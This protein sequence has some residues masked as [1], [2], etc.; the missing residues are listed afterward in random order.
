MEFPPLAVEAEAGH[1]VGV[2]E[3][4][5]PGDLGAIPGE[6][7]SRTVSVIIVAGNNAHGLAST[8]E[9][10]HRALVVTADE[11][12][13][14]I[15]DDGSTDGTWSVAS[16]LARQFH[17]V[18]TFRNESSKGAGY[19]F[20]CGVSQ[21]QLNFLAYVPADNT[22]PY[23]SYVELFG[24]IGKADIITSYS[25]NLLSA[26]SPPRRLLSRVY[27]V[28]LNGIFRLGL[29]YYNGLT[30]YP[31]AYLKSLRHISPGLSFQA[32]T[33]IAA[34]SSGYSF[35]EVVLPVDDCNVDKSRAATPRN[36]LDAAT[37]IFRL[38]GR[39]YL[40]RP[41]RE[42]R[43]VAQAPVERGQS[44]DELGMGR[45]RTSTSAAA[46]TVKPRDHMRIVITGA[47]SGI[48]E[49]FVN[50]LAKDGHQIFCCARRGDELQRI[51]RNQPSVH[52]VVCDVADEADIAK[53][54]SAVSGEFDGIDALINSVGTFGEIGPVS[55]IDNEEWWRTLKVNVLGPY[56]T[57]KYCLPLLEKGRKARII[58]LAGGGAFSPF[59]NYS[60]YA[61][62][63]AAL[64]RLT[65]CLA[66]ELRQ[67]NIRVNAISPG[68]VATDI[69][70]ATIA[71]GEE[72]AGRLQ[73]R[74]TLAIMQDGGAAL[75]D[76]IN[77]LKAMLSPQFDRL[78]GKTISANFD[79]WQTKAFMTHIDDITS[80]DLYTMRRMNL[81][82]L[83]DGYLRK[84]LAEAW[85]NFGS[86]T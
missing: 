42:W 5:E 9:R 22:W 30:V 36:V 47:S 24:N 52:T 63:K 43:R 62:S 74:R 44:I 65:E 67:K 25:D 1:A 86:G 58:N 31:A 35:I 48:G 75:D 14:L 56:L 11:S 40:K 12:E 50:A 7:T 20:K 16:E 57:I 13:I 53:L 3:P 66:V 39:I 83:N 79:P 34:I 68:I 51:A 54:V 26:M 2:Y 60:A 32:E 10:L 70:K 64:V 82:N 6:I 85:A 27:T 55:L 46:P 41:S 45:G 33:L 81:T 19:C 77:C 37:M 61:C 23:R 72:R 29:R 28:A 15:V 49:A 80:S 76:V 38:G 17:N 21:A 84:R 71:A 69:H 4:T 18:R 78:T 73:Y 8:V 59:P